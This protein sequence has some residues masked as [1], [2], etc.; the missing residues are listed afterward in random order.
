MKG[1]VRGFNRVSAGWTWRRGEGGGLSPSASSQSPARPP[2][3]GR[4]VLP[5]LVSFRVLVLLPPSLRRGF[6]VQLDAVLLQLRAQQGVVIFQ[7][8]NLNNSSRGD[9][10]ETLLSDLQPS[11]SQPH[12]GAPPAAPLVTG[13]TGSAGSTV[14]VCDWSEC[15]SG[16][17]EA[18]LLPEQLVVHL[19]PLH[20]LVALLQLLVVLPQ[21]SD[22]V[23]GFGQDP[24]F[25][26]QHQAQASRSREARLLSLACSGWRGRSRGHQ[27]AVTL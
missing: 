9:V 19:H 24:S 15:F 10:K 3:R 23:T 22:V 12:G 13:L 5:V 14:S 18:N 21:L 4:V 11:P 17:C 8:L 27:Q 6:S 20:L 2:A 16:R 26:L 7:L 25:T 1:D